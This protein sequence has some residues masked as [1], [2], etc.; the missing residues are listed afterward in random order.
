MNKF[1]IVF[2]H[3]YM[4][5]I[6]TKS[7][8]ISTAITL[9]FII[10]LANIQS[11]IDLFADEGS[12]EVALMDETG[13]FAEPLQAS[14][15]EAEEDMEIVLFD[16]REEQAKQAVTDGE[17]AAFV[18]LEQDAEGIF[19]ASYYAESLT[20][21]LTQTALEQHLQ[22]IKIAIAT[23]QSGMDEA[24]LAS[25]YTP[26]EIEM[27]ALDES[28]KTTEE[29]SQARG[30]VYIILILLYVSVITYGQMIATDVAA[31]K[32]SRVM[33]ILISSAAPVTHMFAKILGVGM[34]GLTQVALFIGVGYTMIGSRQDDLTGGFFSVF[35]L[36]NTSPSIY[37]YGVVFFLLGY[38]LFATIAAMV[39]SV[40]SRLEDVNQFM[41][42]V[43]MLLMAGFF[44]A[45]FGMGMPEATFIT[46]M[47]FIPLFTPMVMFLRVG[48]LHV[49]VW[50]IALSI[51][52]LIGTI[53]L[54]AYIGAKVYSGGVLMYGKSGS[55]KDLKKAMALS[56]KEN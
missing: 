46:V 47:S 13:L 5:R 3:T 35:G 14:L 32:S 55:F 39:G 16:G 20:G 30:I 49:P 27:I 40:V 45:A 11:I 48:L 53:A 19:R 36:Q 31:E 29:M 52:L 7:F 50:E 6:K 43:S 23:Q 4:K 2:S 37:I 38:F 34:V 9:L 24:T 33:E 18:M 15:D 1:W 51:G 8:L 54:L 10:G 12:S 25:I 21:S 44:V 42:P 56:K 22:Q 17:Y 28:A 26:M 41:M